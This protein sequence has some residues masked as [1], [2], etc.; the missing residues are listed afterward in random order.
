M[1]MYRAI[2]YDGVISLFIIKGDRMAVATDYEDHV[3]YNKENFHFDNWCS[4]PLNYE[5][6]SEAKFIWE[7]ED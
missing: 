2:D 6:I 7:K 4:E 5:R 3:W 1:R